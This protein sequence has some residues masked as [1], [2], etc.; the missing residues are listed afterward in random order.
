MASIAISL[1]DNG[2]SAYPK[3][4]TLTEILV[5]EHRIFNRFFD[6]MGNALPRLSTP[7]EGRL[8]GQMMMS[9]LQDHAAAETDL[10]YIALDHVLQNEGA[11]Q[12]MH[13][14]HRE[15]D[16]SLEQVQAAATCAEVRRLL[17]K[18][19]AASREH[20]KAEERD[21]FPL[22]ERKLQDETLARL[23]EAWTQGQPIL[24]EKEARPVSSL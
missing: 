16:A 11:L 13:H 14:D 19:I 6:Q 15:L 23:G 9:L 22:L 5:T 17:K 3:C 8:L 2:A 24:E 12:R 10:A 7:Q 20:F 4:M 1:A 21:V 18:A